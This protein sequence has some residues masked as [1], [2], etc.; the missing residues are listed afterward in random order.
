MFNKVGVCLFNDT[1]LFKDRG[2][3][4]YFDQNIDY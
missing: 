2:S 4:E 3:H 1:H